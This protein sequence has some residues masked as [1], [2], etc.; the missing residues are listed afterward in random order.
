MYQNVSQTL[1]CISEY[2]ISKSKIRQ[3]NTRVILY[4]KSEVMKG[5][6]SHEGGEKKVIFNSWAFALKK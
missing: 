1:E 2:S 3:T 6:W 5:N 4:Y